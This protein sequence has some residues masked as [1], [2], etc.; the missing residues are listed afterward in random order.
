[1]TACQ[2]R[3]AQAKETA[4]AEFRSAQALHPLP[5]V[6][7]LC[8]PI[9][10]RFIAVGL[11]REKGPFIILDEHWNPHSFLLCTKVQMELEA[12]DLGHTKH[13]KISTFADNSF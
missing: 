5:T 6:S 3:P 8:S 10:F 1:M 9:V 12:M 11:L 4:S 2:M 13:S 7:V